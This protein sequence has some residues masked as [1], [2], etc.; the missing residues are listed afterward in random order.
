[1]DDSNIVPFESKRQRS[2]EINH[3]LSN[4]IVGV[5]RTAMFFRAA[6]FTG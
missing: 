4:V 6:P 5:V 2:E 3:R 1:M